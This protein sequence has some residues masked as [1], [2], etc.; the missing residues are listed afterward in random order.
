M[1]DLF[2][3]SSRTEKEGAREIMTSGL[4]RIQFTE[5]V[6]L[7][8]AGHRPRGIYERIRAFLGKPTPSSFVVSD[9]TFYS[10]SAVP[11]TFW[12]RIQ[13]CNAILRGKIPAL[14]E[15]PSQSSLT[16]KYEEAP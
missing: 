13:L 11:E 1:I 10:G 15:V 4:T 6:A 8:I 3:R 14:E 2:G 5:P 7:H 16:I 9:C 12:P